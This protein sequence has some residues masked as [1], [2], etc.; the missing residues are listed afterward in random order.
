MNSIDGIVL[1][2]GV[3]VSQHVELLFINILFQQRPAISFNLEYMQYYY[4][5]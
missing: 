1:M 4:F 2:G 5:G 3:F